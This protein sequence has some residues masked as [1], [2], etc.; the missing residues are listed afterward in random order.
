MSGTALSDVIAERELTSGGGKGFLRIGK[1]E[2][3]TREG[4]D[5]RCTFGDW[6]C[7]FEVVGLGDDIVQEV[8]GID[9]MQAL[10]LC[11]QVAE[12]VLTER[13]R[14]SELGWLGGEGHGLYPL[15]NLPSTG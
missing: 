5:W 3:D 11:L 9:S 14:T 4:G 13:S 8:F 12:V 1:P 15:D 7:T 10:Q 6:R 2:P